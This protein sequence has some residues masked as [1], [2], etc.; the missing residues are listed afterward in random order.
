MP[1]VFDDTAHRKMREL[2]KELTT[3]LLRANEQRMEAGLAAF[4]LARCMRPLLDNYG[5]TAAHRLLLDTIVA[6]LRHDDVEDEAG[7]KLL[8]M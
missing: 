1:L 5:E 3:V 4:A 6:F 2:Q 7:R 8:V